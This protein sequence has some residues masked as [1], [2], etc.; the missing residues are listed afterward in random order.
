[1]VKFLLLL[2]FLHCSAASTYDDLLAWAKKEGARF[3]SLYV[4]E[5]NRERGLYTQTNVNA[6]EEILYVPKKL[7]LSV[8]VA[9]NESGKDLS[10]ALSKVQERE[11]FESFALACLLLH[12]YG[13]GKKSY[14]Y[15]FIH[16]LP[17]EFPSHPLSLH[18]QEGTLTHSLPASYK[19][20]INQAQTVIVNYKKYA[21]E[22]CQ[23]NSIDSYICSATLDL[24]KW[25]I[26]IIWSRS[27]RL[28]GSTLALIPIFDFA[29]H[30]HSVVSDIFLS[31]DAL[32]VYA[33]KQY[34]V[35]E[36]FCWKY[37]VFANTNAIFRQGWA[38][39]SLFSSSVGTNINLQFNWETEF[40]E[41]RGIME[42]AANCFR[43][44]FSIPL[45]ATP[46]N[47]LEISLRNFYHKHNPSLL[48][49]AKV[50]KVA[51]HFQYDRNALKASLE[52]KYKTMDS[53]MVDDSSMN[54]H[55]LDDFLPLSLTTCLR[56]S[57]FVLSGACSEEEEKVQ[58]VIDSF[59][60]NNG[61][62]YFLSEENEK[63]AVA[64]LLQALETKDAELHCSQFDY[65]N[66]MLQDK[67]FDNNSGDAIQ[68]VHLTECLT[69]QKYQNLGK[70]IL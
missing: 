37:S 45:S 39:F 70:R 7:H 21:S 57:P 54:L 23:K 28:Q 29:N 62:L 69:I 63:S 10:H 30:C 8:D 19:E 50:E 15:D 41:L 9:M 55:K 5:K 47:N 20:K 64:I 59:Y 56:L 48:L 35:G 66:E 53:F 43:R 36:E 46:P 17:K 11:D 49:E 52:R 6:G 51:Q 3:G 26:L 16:T 33:T 13:K 27:I 68:F 18:F 2:L 60:E 31:N 1:M 38:D 25:S 12:E 67:Q 40:E 32:R 58:T 4:K 44:E 14:W 42:H 34:K 24:W 65:K 22:M 61:I